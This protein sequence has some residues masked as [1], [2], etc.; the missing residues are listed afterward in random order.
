[1]NSASR[2]A[3]DVFTEACTR[4]PTARS[5]YVEQACGDQIEVRDEVLRL[6]R[7]RAEEE[8]GTPSA[9]AERVRA[10]VTDRMRVTFDTD[11]G[12]P[13]RIDSFR[14]LH[15]LGAGGMGTVFLAEQ[16]EPRRHVALKI[17]RADL[18]TPDSLHR[19]ELESRLLARLRHPSI[20]RIYATG[21]FG[22]PTGELPYLAMEYV[23][24]HSLTEHARTLGLPARLELFAAICDAVSHAHQKGVIHRDLKP[25][26]ILIDRHGLPKV[27][28]FGV[29]RFRA[30]T[31]PGD[32][33]QTETGQVI[34]TLNYMSPEQAGGDRDIDTR[35][36]VYSLGVLGFELVAGRLP[37]DLTQLPLAE[38]LRTI[39]ED[40][41]PSINAES[42]RFRGDLVLIFQKALEI[43]RKRR[44]PSAV[45]LAEDVR[46]FLADETVLARPPTL[47]YQLRRFVRRNRALVGTGLVA[48]LLLVGGLVFA[49]FLTAEEARQR[50]RAEQE[51]VRARQHEET[52]SR[53][54]YAAQ[55]Q[56]ASL[57]LRTHDSQSA[58]RKLLAT[59]P[60]LRGWEWRYLKSRLDQD[61]DFF[62]MALHHQPLLAFSPDA[63]RVVASV[64]ERT[65]R[66]FD[67]AQEIWGE[68]IELPF[69][70]ACVA[71]LD[72]GRVLVAEGPRLRILDD[73]LRVVFNAQSTIAA[74]RPAR[75][76]GQLGV[77]T[78]HEKRS[79]LHIV[80]PGSWRTLK[81]LDL[82]PAAADFCFDDNASRVA[83]RSA[84]TLQ[85]W[86]MHT[87]RLVYEHAGAAEGVALSGDGSRIAHWNPWGLGAT[88]VDG[89]PSMWTRGLADDR[90]GR[91]VFA[92][93]GRTLVS[94]HLDATL[95]FWDART[96]TCLGMSSGRT[97]SHGDLLDL[98]LT[99]DGARIHTIGLDGAYVRPANSDPAPRVLRHR[100]RTAGNTYPYV[101][102]V[103]FDPDGRRVAT[104]GWDGTI[105]IWDVATGRLLTVFE[106]ENHKVEWVRF[107]RD[108]TRLLSFSRVGR[109]DGARLNL[110]NLVTGRREKV[111][112]TDERRSAGV[113]GP[114]NAWTVV[115]GTEVQILDPLS[116]AVL[117]RRV[118]T[119]TTVR[120]LALSPDEKWIACGTNDACVIL[121]SA[122]LAPVRRL[123]TVAS[124]IAFSPDGLRL[125]TGGAGGKLRVWDLMT[126]HRIVQ[127]EVVRARPVGGSPAL[128]AA[129]GVPTIYTVAFTP[130][131]RR[132]ACGCRMGAILLFDAE[133]GDEIMRLV[134]HE[135]Y[136]HELAFGR[137]GVMLASASGDNTARLWDT[138]SIAVRLAEERQALEAEEALQPYVDALFGRLETKSAV[139]EAIA[140]DAGLEPDARHAALNHVVQ[141]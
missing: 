87:N 9:F 118:V 5:A 83:I 17:L 30:A 111:V 68:P 36:D 133:S 92:A 124:S 64:G 40:P 107:S 113:R 14:I 117:R 129:T 15:R 1:M 22:S 38:A 60:E 76:P 69:A 99:T 85:V 91:V 77:L 29:S 47:T 101:Y 75:S 114:A 130:D 125:A 24:G 123:K 70:P 50:E 21:R 105:R 54:A 39:Q 52:A 65:L 10:T 8:S 96:G 109:T 138:R 103:C 12:Q 32:I 4:E 46:R 106:H 7:L 56:A 59:Q 136:V 61:L 94:A 51:T 141:R 127:V 126:G 108:G 100:T 79:V 86:D 139:A 110:W 28:D 19:F 45:A 6:L 102:S 16:D 71:M 104:S 140:A 98:A 135:A 72:D 20:A 35:A 122:T 78:T 25:G 119:G 95:R 131:G 37:R 112:R 62:P 67:F 49:L 48:L 13:D 27:L 132:V 88:H 134:G 137:D 89:N 26:N 33:D 44:Y 81:A 120:A 74:V 53:A 43:D 121:D 55:I 57:A 80:Q 73:D 2:R 93:G 97:E 11:L 66:V 115:T 84:N 31:A 18:I 34:G 41:P 128:T 90:T 23:D 42:R 58:H 3:F 63:S 82:P 116:L